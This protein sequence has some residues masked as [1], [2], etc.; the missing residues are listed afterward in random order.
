MRFPSMRRG[1]NILL[2]ASALACVCMGAS[3]QTFDQLLGDFAQRRSGTCVLYA[4]VMAV[5]E[6]DPAV[7][8]QRV[9]EVYGGWMTNFP[10]GRRTYVAKEELETSLTNG[11]SAGE[12]GNILTIYCIAVSKR[13][14]GFDEKTGQLDYGELDWL[15]FVT[16]DKWTG[17]GEDQLPGNK[18]KDGLARISQ[19]SKTDDHVRIPCT[20]GFGILNEQTVPKCIDQVRKYKVI[21]GHDFQVV[22]FNHEV[23]AVKLRNPHR[24]QEITEVPVSLLLSIPCGIDFMEPSTGN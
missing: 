24:P 22:G 4:H 9:H 1:I 5:A 10:D 16:P 18:V 14:M 6:Y 3:A 19:E 11:Y 7:F 21:G 12:P 8:A 2:A 23:N 20:I 13:S 15:K 17:Y